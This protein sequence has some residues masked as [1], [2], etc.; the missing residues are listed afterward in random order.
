[1]IVAD[2]VKKLIEQQRVL[3]FSKTTCPFCKKSKGIFSEF[4]ANPYVVELDEH[5]EGGA[6]QEEL[7]KVT[8][9]K[10]VPNIFING[11]HIGGCSDLVALKDKGTL[12]DLLKA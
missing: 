9:Q 12:A 6:I 11:K 1:M 2:F 4:N 5:A 10:T 3:L 8:G 7:A